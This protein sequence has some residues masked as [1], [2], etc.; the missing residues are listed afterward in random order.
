MAEPTRDVLLFIMIVWLFCLAIFAL[1][2]IARSIAKAQRKKRRLREM[3]WK[4]G[5]EVHERMERELNDM[6]NKCTCHDNVWNPNCPI[7]NLAM[8]DKGDDTYGL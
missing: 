5:K 4:L 6:F 8:F 1:V 2:I 3:G 7:H